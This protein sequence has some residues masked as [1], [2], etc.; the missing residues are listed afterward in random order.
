MNIAQYLNKPEYIF[1][2]SQ[3]CRRMWHTIKR[4]NNE[5]ERVALPWKTEINVRPN[6]VIGHSIVTMGVYDLCV[7]EVLWR[8]IDLGDTAVDVGAN[9]GY[10][11][12]I[13]AK[14]VGKTGRVFSYEPHP[15]IYEEFCE[16]KRMW[17]GTC[18]LPQIESRQI[19]LSN[20][21]G[22]GMLNMPPHFKDN[23]SVASILDETCEQVAGSAEQCPVIL[24]RL[25][26]IINLEHQIAIIKLDV[27]GH[28]LKVLQGGS[29]IITHNVRDIIFEEHKGFPNEA[30]LF[31]ES[32]G[33]T[34]FRL[35]KELWG[36]RLEHP[37]G[38]PGGHLLPWEPPNYL[39]TKEPMR[40][41]ERLKKRGWQAF[42]DN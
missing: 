29:K 18:G 17:Q 13:M 28:E 42:S 14:R 20:I 16:N 21:S 3:I 15:G 19:A 23:Q 34:V 39:A 33:F 31:L 22:I 8:L 41:I 9:I 11:T 2:P 10:M 12:S 26:D 36:P 38:K 30:S 24:V 27:E 6:E 35:Y 32:R 1:R 25:D 7:T 40:A 4:E 37:G 5:Y